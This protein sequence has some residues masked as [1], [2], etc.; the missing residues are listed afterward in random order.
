MFD[1]EKLNEYKIRILLSLLVILLVIVA[2]FYRGI[3]GIASIEVIFVGLLFSL[4]SIFHASWAIL[5]IK[6]LQ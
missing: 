5:K 4:V 6:K 1:P 3:N 2:V